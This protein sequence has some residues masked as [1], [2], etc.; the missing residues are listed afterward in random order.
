MPL[1]VKPSRP[2]GRLQLMEYMRNHYE[3][4]W[5][6]SSNNSFDAGPGPFQAPYR[7]RP[8]EWQVAGVEGNFINERPIG[9]Q[10]CRKLFFDSRF[11][12]RGRTYSFACGSKL[13]GTLWHSAGLGCRVRSEVFCG[14]ELTTL[15]TASTPHCMLP[16][17][18]PLLLGPVGTARPLVQ[19]AVALLLLQWYGSCVL[20]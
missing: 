8:L 15:P 14:L 10:V 13:A 11:T 4:T 9:V 17:D 12:V 1:F 19:A 20:E 3:G 5:L 6:A 16:P 18:K 7:A 2:I